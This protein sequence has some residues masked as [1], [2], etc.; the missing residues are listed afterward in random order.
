MRRVIRVV[1]GDDNANDRYFLQR[2]FKSVRP[3]VAVDFARS[4]EEVILCLQDNSQPEPLLLIIDSMMTKMNGFDVVSWLRARKQFE[5]LPVVMLT[6]QLSESNASRARE[7]RV[8]A[9]LE[10]PDNFAALQ[11]LVEDLGR[12]YLERQEDV[13]GL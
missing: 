1:V 5:N 8:N 2:A 7:F 13:T 12:K 10:K 3:D 11:E 6:G 4:G 9:Y